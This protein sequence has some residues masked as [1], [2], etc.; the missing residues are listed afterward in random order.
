M[1]GLQNI[2][3]R[4]MP[5]DLDNP[6]KRRIVEGTFQSF[7]IQGI[8]IALVF[9][10]NLLLARWAGAS[11]YGKYV[12]VFNWISIL[13]VAAIGGR[14]DL[15]ITKYKVEGRPGLIFS[16]IGLLNRHVLIASVL[17]SLAFLAVIFL[18]P[19]KTL[20]EYRIEFLI[21]SA[22]VY[23]TAFLTLNQLVLQ[24]LDHIRLSQY[25]ER[26]IKPFLLIL[27]FVIAQKCSF[28][29]TGDLLIV[30]AVLAMAICCVI[31]AMIVRKKIKG[32]RNPVERIPWKDSHTKK[33]FYFFFITMLTLLVTK[34]SMLILPYF[35]P[36]KDIGIFNIS[37]RFADLIIYPFFLMHTV[38]PQLFSTH[39]DSETAYKQS[40][41]S[42]S[43]KLMLILSLPLFALNVL[44]GKWFL[45]WFGQ[46]FAAG[47]TALVLLSSAQL[48]FPVFGP[49]NT[50]LMMQGK[51][52]YSA[53]CL[54]VYVLVLLLSSAWLIP[55]MGITGG[56]IAMLISCLVYNIVLSVLVYRLSGV[57]S[58]FFRWL[59]SRSGRAV[60]GSKRKDR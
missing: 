5:Q 8:S 46:E 36:Q 28:S 31:L 45:G 22:A 40:L 7:I 24:A 30:L 58:P 56:A 9:L 41:Y 39:T 47:Y 57:I 25:V 2:F 6:E 27:F 15:A 10:S 14:E 55:V 35:A 19:V 60:A 51:E 4:F 20:H 53:I 49:A 48:L 52:K 1:N 37:Y 17:I 26:L 29:L 42:G 50:I 16:L 32:F 43:A 13:G 44:A 18:I 54:L 38:L 21:A 33:T 59:I 3:S 11:A 34:I 23:F 12:H